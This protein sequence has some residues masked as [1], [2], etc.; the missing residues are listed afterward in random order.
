MKSRNW[1]AT[2]CVEA[3][4]F[5]VLLLSMASIASAEPQYIRGLTAKGFFSSTEVNAPIVTL[6]AGVR[7]QDLVPDSR[8]ELCDIELENYSRTVS[9][10]TTVRILGDADEVLMSCGG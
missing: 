5:T 3:R 4:A 9:G 10:V 2:A 8:K 1:L 6:R 7:F